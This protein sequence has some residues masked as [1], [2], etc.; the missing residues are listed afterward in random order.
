MILLDAIYINNGG[1]K[2][3]LDYLILNLELT[4]KKIYYLLD[5]RVDI[6]D[7]NISASNRVNLME[8]NF[9]NRQGFYK[10]NKNTF[11][12]VICFGNLPPNIKVN[13]VVFTYFHQPMYLKIP[14]DFSLTEKLKF[15][16]KTKIL[17]SIKK[18]TNYW[19]VQ[20]ETI[21]TGLIQTYKLNYAKVLV[22]PFYPPFDKINKVPLRKKF[23]YL[24]VSNAP[25]HK[26]HIRLIDAFCKFYDKKQVGELILTVGP[27]YDN[28]I[29]LISEKISTGYPI[30]NVGFINRVELH[31]LYLASEYLIFPSLAESF[32]LG[33]VE[34]IENGCKVIGADLPYM[35]EVCEPSITFNP[36][37]TKSIK[38]ALE[39]SLLDNIPISK[40]IITNK[41][42]EL[43]ALLK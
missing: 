14:K 24:Y 35:Y 43:I 30:V 41:I 22:I 10:R 5:A 20:N 21:R 12:T 42:N 7:Y 1:G 9:L 38:I 25:S 16:I 8:A 34:A 32:G 18:N 36:L 15:W 39:K 37:D 2:I 19:L 28:I 6:S 11:S 40:Q 33:L 4:N 26:N 17:K 29:N 13:T 23:S 3:L 27:L 31:E